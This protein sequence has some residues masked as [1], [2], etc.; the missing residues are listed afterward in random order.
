MQSLESEDP[1]IRAIGE[2]TKAILFM[3]TP[4]KGSPVAKL[5]QHTQLILSPTI[6]V[7]EMYENAKHLL[8]LNDKFLEIVNSRPNQIDVVSFVE[9]L[10]TIFSTTFKLP[11]RIVS[12]SSALINAGD[13]YIF[14][15]DHL[16]ICKPVFRQSFL[17]QRV[18]K[19]IE[20]SMPSTVKSM[21]IH[22]NGKE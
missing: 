20:K 22:R 3:G 1:K 6:E 16:G 9:G 19:L 15:D 5:K 12:E 21:A 7:V 18:L 4:H 17:Y 11:F 2:N 8:T 13:T 10:P 14:N